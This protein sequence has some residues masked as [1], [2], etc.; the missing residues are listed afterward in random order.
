MSTMA[1]RTLKA[2]LETLLDANANGLYSVEGFQRQSH[3]AEGLVGYGRHV[4]VFYRQG[5]F[6]K[7][8]SG[9]LQGPFKHAVTY[10]VE[11]KLAA[12]AHADLTALDPRV[13]ATPQER[14]SALAAMAPAAKVADDQ[15]DELADLIWNILIAPANA[16]TLGGVNIEDRWIA[17]VQK[18][19]PA[20]LGEYVLLAGTMDYTCTVIETPPGD[21]GIPAA[22]NAIDTTLTG[23]ADQ[24]GAA[25]DPA[26]Q[27]AKT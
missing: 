18:E 3:D 19:M 16:D 17:N 15:W 23:T 6:D 7:A 1:F 5:Q 20:P 25:V 10:Q 14:M 24:T 2:A 4:T 13:P 22:A 27:G 12:P 8:R 26:L 9:W 11:L 21:S